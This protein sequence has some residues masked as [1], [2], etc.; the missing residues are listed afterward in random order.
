MR[1]SVKHL[2][3]ITQTREN[4]FKAILSVEGLQNWWTSQVEGQAELNGTLQ[5]D[6][7]DM[8]GPK[9]KI[10]EIVPNELIVWECIES[11]H[12]WVGNTLKF[13][14]DNNDGKTRVRFAHHGFNEQNE[15]FAICNFTWARYM[16]SLRQYCQ[17]GN[18]EAFGGPNYR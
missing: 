5:F 1:Y 12:G 6:F 7:G 13:M 17:T 15:F 2:F 3:H 11:N 8:K 4:V 18:G 9:M 16:E 14:L 10:I